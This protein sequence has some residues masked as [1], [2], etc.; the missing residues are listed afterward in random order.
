MTVLFCVSVETEELNDLL[1]KFTKFTHLTLSDCEL[2]EMP[3]VTKLIL[4]QDLDVR[5]NKITEFKMYPN[6]R[7]TNIDITEN[8]ILGFDFDENSLSGLKYLKLG[9]EQTKYISLQVLQ[10]LRK[11]LLKIEVSKENLKHPLYPPRDCMIDEEYLMEL[12]AKASLDLTLITAHERKSTLDWVLCHGGSMVKSLDLSHPSGT[13]DSDN[14]NIVEIFE[15]NI[16]SWC[17][18]RSLTARNLG[19][20]QFPDMA[21]LKRLERIDFSNNNIDIIPMRLL[22]IESLCELDLSMNPIVQFDTLLS[23][24]LILLLQG[25]VRH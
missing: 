10:I 8:P 2:Q 12:T 17:N 25:L 1:S 20:R 4:L 19:I 16:G 9:S 3:D 7:L 24:L 15:E 13:Y 23:P 22:P 18:L 5:H 21:V 11:G 14:E 6:K